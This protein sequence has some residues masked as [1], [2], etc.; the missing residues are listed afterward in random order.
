MRKS[1][2]LFLIAAFLLCGCATTMQSGFGSRLGGG[3]EN[4]PTL[5]PEPKPDLGT[6]RVGTPGLGNSGSNYGSPGTNSNATPGANL[7][8][9]DPNLEPSESSSQKLAPTRP[10][11]IL[12]A[13]EASNRDSGRGTLPLLAQDSRFSRFRPTSAGSSNPPASSSPPAE[14]ASLFDEP[15]WSRSLRSTEER[16]IETVVLGKGARK[17]AVLASL[18]GDEE[19]SVALVEELARYLK[20]HAGQFQDVRVLI[21]RTPNPDGQS[22]RSPYNVHGVDLNRNFPSANWKPV[23][24]NRGGDRPAS[25]VETRAIV[26]LLTDFQPDL[27]LHVKDSRGAGTINLEGS[28]EAFASAAARQNSYRIVRNLGQT[29]SGSLENYAASRLHCPSLTLLLPKEKGDAAAWAKNSDT[30]LAP[31]RQFEKQTQDNSLGRGVDPFE[32]PSGRGKSAPP[33]RRLPD[34]NNV[35]YRKLPEF[36]APVPDHGYLELPPPGR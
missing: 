25:E 17:V 5:N 24:S 18:H 33:P 35:G 2:C 11:P 1:T 29:T 7:G 10:G 8:E 21:V 30:L 13:P 19:Q 27:I 14:R 23:A 31:L 3:T 34:T 36:P 6:P 22:G 4:D 28:G 12:E 9:P 26:R 15:I 32:R 16:L 20:R